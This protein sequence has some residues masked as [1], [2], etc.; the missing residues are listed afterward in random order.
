MGSEEKELHLVRCDADDAV[1][2]H[3][4]GSRAARERSLLSSGL[5]GVRNGTD[6]K[7]RVPEACGLAGLDR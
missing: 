6:P 5:W 3:Q 2:G 1:Q 7:A 4:I